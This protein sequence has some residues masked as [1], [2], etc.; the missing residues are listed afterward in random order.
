MELKMNVVFA[1]PSAPPTTIN[2]VTSNKLNVPQLTI[3]EILFFP[4]LFF[5]IH[6]GVCQSHCL[7]EQKIDFSQSGNPDT[8]TYYDY[9]VKHLADILVTHSLT[10]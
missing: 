4:F 7:L 10:C 1:K 8:G 3:G 6:A 5:Q 9:T 2:Y